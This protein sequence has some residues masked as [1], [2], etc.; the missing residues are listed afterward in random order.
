M[1]VFF[2][3]YHLKDKYFNVLW[4]TLLFLIY[5]RK[6][7]TAPLGSGHFKVRIGWKPFWCH[8]LSS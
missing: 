6:K 5:I 8:F 7:L 1:R 3:V 4:A 2:L